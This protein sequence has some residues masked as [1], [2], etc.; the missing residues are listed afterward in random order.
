MPQPTKPSTD[1][2]NL[3]RN[4]NSTA[5]SV[6]LG[7]SM[8]N[9]SDSQ[10][11][12]QNRDEYQPSEVRQSDSA[13]RSSAE[14]QTTQT[15][16]QRLRLTSIAVLRHLKSDELDW[17][18]EQCEWMSCD[19]GQLILNQ[20]ESSNDVYFICSGSVKGAMYSTIGQQVIYQTMAEG[21]MFGEIAAIDGAPRSVQVV[22]EGNCLLARLSSNNF[23]KLMR[24]NP[25]FSLA[26]TRQIIDTTRFLTARVFEFSAFNVGQRIELELARLAEAQGVYEED[27]LV[28]VNP[29]T[30]ADIAGRVNTHREA[31]TKHINKLCKQGTLAK[32]GR[33][34]IILD[35]SELKSEITD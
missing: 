30:H 6:S 1:T 12:N 11:R 8:N 3:S 21:T 27:E 24:G 5:D 15:A 16:M 25:E 29:P 7:N 31:V 22:A 33:T 35:I 18:N 17:L 9:R 19:A 23:L 13:T 4:Q 32:R 20:D 14:L 10:N 2:E 34:L 28:L 26:V